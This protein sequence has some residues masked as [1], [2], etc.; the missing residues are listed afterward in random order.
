MFEMT[1]VMGLLITLV[2]GFVDFG[3]AFYQW[4]AAAKAVQIG[5]RLAAV[6]TPVAEGIPLEA[7]AP[8]ST[9][10]VG[11]PVPAGQYH[12]YCTATAL[13]VASCTCDA[14]TCIDITADQ[15]AFDRIYYGDDRGLEACGVVLPD[16]RGGMCDFFP[17]IEADEVR[18]D[19][20]ATGLGYWTRPGGPVPT[21]SVSVVGRQFDFFFLAFADITMPS[22]L[23][24]IT[25]EDLST[26][27]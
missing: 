25:G 13:G 4:N 14:G 24:T 20:F 18:I 26:S 7:G 15:D 10:D 16:N 17:G 2:L 5:A 21:I 8:A 1:L 19:Y 9:S 3:Y 22:M 6:S 11:L 12:Y 23:S 27:F